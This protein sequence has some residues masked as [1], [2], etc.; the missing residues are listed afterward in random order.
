MKNRDF[1]KIIIK[2]N[3]LEIIEESEEVGRSYLGK[4]ESNLIS[5][6]LLFENNLFEEAVSL[7]YYSMYNLVMSL[8]YRVG[9]KCEN[10][11]AS[12]FLLK[13]IFELD[14]SSLFFAKKER[15][16]KQYYTDFIIKK[17]EVKELIQIAEDFNK[18]I[19]GFIAKLD[20]G[21][22]KLYRSKFLELLG[23]LKRCIK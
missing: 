1:L 3:K 23:G 9:I 2:Q 7:A 17:E 22:V 5:A 6:K 15:L 8:F 10:H 19:L 18:N 20:A 13:D 4:S 14:N 16:D 21:K 11:S 12:V